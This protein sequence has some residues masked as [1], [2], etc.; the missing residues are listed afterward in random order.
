MNRTELV[1]VLE[2]VKPALAASNIIPIFQCFAFDGQNVTASNDAL[3]IIAPCPTE[4]TFA[5]NG[6]TLLGWLRNLSTPEVTFDLGDEHEIKVKSGRSNFK[7]P[8]FP[9]EDFLFAEPKCEWDLKIPL[10][11]AVWGGIQACLQTVGRDMTREGLMGVCVKSIGKSTK[12]Y[13][14]DGDTVTSYTLNHLKTGRDESAFTLPNVFCDALMRMTEPTDLGNS[15]IRINKDW[16]VAELDTGFKVYG[17]M[18]ENPDPLDHA[19]LIKK[20]LKDEPEFIPVPEGFEG[21]LA[22]ARV[23]ADAES[24]KTAITITGSK[25]NITTETHAGTVKDALVVSEHLDVTLNIAAA[26]V[27]SGIKL[28]REVAFRENCTALRLG[29]VVLQIIANM[30]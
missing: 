3:T 19:A 30:E 12:L 8:W 7:L 15:C 6:N 17:R 1:K 16:A 14:C 20:T 5:V 2:A 4:E 25:M 11:G 22:R 13:S 24:A 27:E 26:K 29:D 9:R 28:C 21:A 23:I 18:L 10:D